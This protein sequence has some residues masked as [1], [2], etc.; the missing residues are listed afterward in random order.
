MSDTPR[1]DAESRPYPSPEHAQR[2]VFEGCQ[3]FVMAPEDYEALYEHARQLERELQDAQARIRQLI[4]ERDSARA[5]RDQNWKLRDEFVALLGTDDVKE[6]AHEVRR[7]KAAVLLLRQ[8]GGVLR[9]YTD[10]DTARAREWDRFANASEGFAPLS[11]GGT[12]A[13]RGAA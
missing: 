6:G 5:I 2:I 3:R 13:S 12:K 4:A 8:A 11:A 1:T 7:L 9:A 10:G